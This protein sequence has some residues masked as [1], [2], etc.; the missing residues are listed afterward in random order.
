[1]SLIRRFSLRTEVYDKL[2]GTPSALENLDYFLRP[3]F[4]QKPSKIYNLNKAVE[5]QRP[6]R[7]KEEE[8]TADVAGLE[9]YRS[10]DGK[11]IEFFR[12][13]SEDGSVKNI[14][15]SNILIRI[16]F[17]SDRGAV[18]MAYEIEDIRTSQEIFYYLLEHHELK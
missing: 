12:V 6:V 10:E 7:K 9:I 17:K 14:R 1:M 2:L 15:C 16:T 4:N 13:K 8:E 3:L 11:V 5:L 18:I